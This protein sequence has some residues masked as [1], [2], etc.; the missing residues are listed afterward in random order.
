MLQ[1]QIVPGLQTIV[2]HANELMVVLLARSEEPEQPRLLFDGEEVL[3]FRS[4]WDVYKLEDWSEQAHACL[5][6]N[7]SVMV[8]E[9]LEGVLTQPDGGGQFRESFEHV[10]HVPIESVSVLPEHESVAIKEPAVLAWLSDWW[11]DRVI[12]T[13]CWFV[14]VIALGF[15][16]QSMWPMTQQYPVVAYNH[17]GVKALHENKILY[18]P[19]RSLRLFGT[20][21]Y[22]SHTGA[23]LI[24]THL[25]TLQTYRWNEIPAKHAKALELRPDFSWWNQ[26][27]WWVV[28]TIVLGVSFCLSFLPL[29]YLKWANV[30]TH[31][32]QKENL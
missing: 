31:K 25:P 10:Y 14:V 23:F 2:N 18:Q 16:V 30:F 7:D 27:G 26:Q 5:Q 3:L 13:F 24:R 29:R 9:T 4:P 32:A 12:F 8:V 1:A 11:F 21:L 22:R 19:K 6:A 20:D 17:Y 15:V 28:L